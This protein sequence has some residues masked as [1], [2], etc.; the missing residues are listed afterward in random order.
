[1]EQ[2]GWGIKGGW[3]H[4]EVGKGMENCRVGKAQ[5]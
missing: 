5:V 3:G 1:M 2:G 4:G